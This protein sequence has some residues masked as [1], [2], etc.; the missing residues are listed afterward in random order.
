M[1]PEA[2]FPDVLRG[3]S[4]PDDAAVLKIDDNTAL[5]LTA[6]FFAP[7]VDDPYEF[8]AIAAT[9][10]LSDVYAMGARPV[11]AINLASFP[12][13]L[14]PAILS[15]IL[16]G[17]AEKVLEAGAIIAGGHTTKDDEPKYGLAVVGMV[18][19]DQLYKNEG[20][21]VGDQLLLTKPLGT[22]VIA[23]ALKRESAEPASIRAA[24][25][26][27]TR[28]SAG[29]VAALKKAGNDAVHAVTDVTGFS[30]IGHGHEM[31]EL[32]GVAMKINM[33]QLPFL[34]GATALAAQGVSSGGL[35]RNREYYGQ[36]LQQNETNSGPEETLIFDPQT[37]GG[38]L[39]AVSAA[40]PK[41]S[42]ALT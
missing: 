13:T 17:G 24:I 36:W 6:D 40:E 26:S 18:A 2:D 21:Q 16:R 38:L 39:V 10:A 11:L 34:P 33:D 8:G 14:D 32:S 15:E 25:D 41:T 3:L 22:G 9:N 29:A 4:S 35:D 23:T 19:I 28:L 30:L 7:I 12:D 42:M 20:A 37:S 31:A 27:M 5:V 1:F